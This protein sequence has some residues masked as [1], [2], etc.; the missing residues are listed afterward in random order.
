M[1]V[2]DYRLDRSSEDGLQANRRIARLHYLTEARMSKWVIR[3]DCATRP[4][5]DPKECFDPNAM[6]GRFEFLSIEEGVQSL[7]GPDEM[8]IG[9]SASRP[10]MNGTRLVGYIQICDTSP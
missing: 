5:G 1:M 8:A 4:L 9:S 2:R 3:Q 6:D 7:L 10:V